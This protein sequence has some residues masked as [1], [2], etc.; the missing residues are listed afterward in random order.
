MVLPYLLLPSS[1]SSWDRTCQNAS[2][3]PLVTLTST[4]AAMQAAGSDISQDSSL[5]TV[6]IQL[7]RIIFVCY[8]PLSV[9]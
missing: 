1:N 7:E 5:P 2:A 6:L 4:K 9:D 8:V 3:S